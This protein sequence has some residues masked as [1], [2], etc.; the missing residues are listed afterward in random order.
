MTCI[1]FIPSAA[2]ALKRHAPEASPIIYKGIRFKSHF[3]FDAGAVEA[4]DA[5]T[6]KKVWQKKV[7][8]V[9]INPH[10][11]FD[12]QWV[13][14]TSLEITKEGD[15]L[16]KDERGGSYVVPIPKEILKE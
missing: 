7:F 13:K 10:M 5:K 15:L 6:G 1:L 2:N 14:I 12:N 4:F 16:V 3:Y 8:D 9:K 11:E